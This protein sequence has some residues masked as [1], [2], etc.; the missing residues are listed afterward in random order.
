[1]AACLLTHGW[2]TIEVPS[3]SSLRQ[4]NHTCANMLQYW[5]LLERSVEWGQSVFD[6]GRPS[7]ESNT[8]R[9]KKQWGATPFLAESQHYVRHGS[10]SDLRPDNPR[11]ERLIR[12]WQ[13]LPGRRDALDRP[14]DRAGDTVIADEHRYG[15]TLTRSKP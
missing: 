9:F 11:Y 2:G 10:A 15:I 12:I 13:R 6:F 3:A 1:M 7:P 14:D 5:K 8:Y 4:Y